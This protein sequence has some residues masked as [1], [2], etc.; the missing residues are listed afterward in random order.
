[1]GTFYVIPKDEDLQHYGILGMKWGIRRYQ[2]ADGSLTAAGKRRYL[3]QDDL[4]NKAERTVK[5]AVVGSLFGGPVGA[6]LGAIGGYKT[7][8]EKINEAHLKEDLIDIQSARIHDTDAKTNIFPR[9]DHRSQSGTDLLKAVKPNATIEEIDIQLKEALREADKRNDKQRNIKKAITIGSSVLALAGT[10]SAVKE[11]SENKNES[12]L[13]ANMLPGVKQ[14]KGLQYIGNEASNVANIINK[15][16]EDDKLKE[17][18]KTG[19][20]VY[21]KVIENTK[22]IS[23]DDMNIELFNW[24]KDDNN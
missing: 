18:Q 1:M 23:E 16:I 15:K 22:N 6:A 21:N 4:Y 3:G 11:Y 2:N 9:V 13:I 19:Q 17:L 7:K 8:Q 20:D 10:I 5:G 24:K 14:F 12:K